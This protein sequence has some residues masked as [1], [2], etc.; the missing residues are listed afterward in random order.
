MLFQA[1][2]LQRRKCEDA[3]ACLLSDQGTREGR[4]VKRFGELARSCADQ[5]FSRTEPRHVRESQDRT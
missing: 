2:D 1:I 4:I 3:F 5:P